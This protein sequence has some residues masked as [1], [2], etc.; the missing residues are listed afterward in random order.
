MRWRGSWRGALRWCWDEW[1]V[2]ADLAAEPPAGI[3]L[4]SGCGRGMTA[5]E[6]VRKS[7]KVGD[8]ALLAFAQ[9]RGMPALIRDVVLRP[10]V[11]DVVAP[12]ETDCGGTG[13]RRG[14]AGGDIFAHRMG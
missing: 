9:N 3:F 5:V 12:G 8:G 11:T 2:R 14:A 13:M 7:N 6:T 1:A 4:Q 10:R